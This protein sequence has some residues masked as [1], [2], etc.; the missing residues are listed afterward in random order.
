MIACYEAGVMV[1][2]AGDTFEFSPPLICER[3]HIDQI[4]EIIKMVLRATH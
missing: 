4:F 1:R 2:I 3:D